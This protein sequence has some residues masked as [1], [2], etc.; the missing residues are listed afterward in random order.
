LRQPLP[1]TSRIAK[2]ANVVVDVVGIVVVVDVVVILV[3]AVVVPMVV[4]KV[5]VAFLP[6]L[7]WYWA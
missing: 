6:P 7:H 2:P 3:V 5:W 1:P 4:V